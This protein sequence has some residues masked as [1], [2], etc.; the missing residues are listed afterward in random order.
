MLNDELREALIE[1][2]KQ[3][4]RR[5]KSS[6]KNP[7]YHKP[8]NAG[9]A[10][11]HLYGSCRALAEWASTENLDLSIQGRSERTDDQSANLAAVRACV[12]ALNIFLAKVDARPK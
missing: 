4:L 6:G 9:A 7:L 5:R 11:T 12:D 10:W 3:G 1:I 8:S 2:A